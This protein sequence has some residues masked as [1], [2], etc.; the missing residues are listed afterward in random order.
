MTLAALA[1]LAQRRVLH[2]KPASWHPS[3]DNAI[4]H[5]HLDTWLCY[6]LPSC[7]G[8]NGPYT[9]RTGAGSSRI[10]LRRSAVH[11]NGTEFCLFPLTNGPVMIPANSKLKDTTIVGHPGANKRMMPLQMDHDSH[12][13]TGRAQCQ[14]PYV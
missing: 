1:P 9:S 8:V 11:E 3:R 5:Q 2:G 10:R 4:W 12:E 13:G 7:M 6:R 14:A